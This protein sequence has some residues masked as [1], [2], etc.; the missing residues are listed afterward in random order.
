MIEIMLMNKCPSIEE[1]SLSHIML[2]PSQMAASF[3]Q[4]SYVYWN[5]KER[6][7]GHNGFP[8]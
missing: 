4:S 7:I 2:L 6:V 1:L 5:F 8:L 3:Q